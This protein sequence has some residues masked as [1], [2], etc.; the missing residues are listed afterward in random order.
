MYENNWDNENRI[1]EEF[2]KWIADKPLLNEN[3][4]FTAI[5]YDFDGN[6]TAKDFKKF[7]IEKLKFIKSDFNDLQI[8]RALMQIS[9][10]GLN[11]ITQ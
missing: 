1:L 4:I 8:E 6:I 2:K 10:L 7:L 3:E 11:D 5:D 9:I